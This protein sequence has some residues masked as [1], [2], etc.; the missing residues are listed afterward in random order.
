MMWTHTK[1][2]LQGPARLLGLSTNTKKNA[3]G[4]LAE[5]LGTE[6]DIIRVEARLP[7][8]NLEKAKTWVAKTLNPRKIS[9]SNLLGF[10][11]FACKV[12]IP[13]R[14][15]LRRSFNALAEKGTDSDQKRST[16]TYGQKPDRYKATEPQRP[17]HNDQQRPSPQRLSHNDRPIKRLTHSDQQRR[18]YKDER[19]ATQPARSNRPTTAKSDHPHATDPQQPANSGRAAADYVQEHTGRYDRSFSHGMIFNSDRIFLNLTF[20]VYYNSQKRVRLL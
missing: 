6:I 19:T 20:A 4:T 8:D 5:F 13:G 10:L 14:A 3:T 9:R 11:S 16:A 7:Q 12:V 17:S 18:T 2:S 1:K 15:F